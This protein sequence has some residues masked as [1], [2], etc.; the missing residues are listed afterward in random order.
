MDCPKLRAIAQKTEPRLSPQERMVFRKLF[1]NGFPV[2]KCR[3][4]PLTLE[5]AILARIFGK[6]GRIL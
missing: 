6:I 5:D 4:L 2:V 1:G 3:T